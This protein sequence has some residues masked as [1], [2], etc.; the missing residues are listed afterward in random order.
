MK[1]KL[2]IVFLF[3][4]A[5]CSGCQRQELEEM[6][7]TTAV[8]P[9]K[10]D[11]SRSGIHPEGAQSSGQDYVHKVSLRFFPQDGTAPF[12]HYLEGQTK[13]GG[14]SIHGGTIRLP[15]GEYAVVAMNE[16][17]LEEDVYWADYFTFS[18]IN[19]FRDISAHTLAKSYDFT[20]VPYDFYKPAP[21]ET[22]RGEAHKLA[23]WRMEHLLVTDEMIARTRAQDTRAN[24][25]TVIDDTLRVDMLH[26][27]QNI[28]IRVPVENGGSIKHMKGVVNGLMTSRNLS[29]REAGTGYS[30]VLFDF[31]GSFT[32]N[33]GGEIFKEHILRTFGRFEGAADMR[34]KLHM[35]VILI[36][37]TRYKGQDMV[38]D[39]T[40]DLK[41]GGFERDILIT[42]PKLRLP[43]MEGAPTVEDWDDD[44]VIPIG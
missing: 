2:N 14:N 39:I 6:S 21:G 36:D 34:Y 9:V 43:Q 26:V 29:S 35:D 15:K 1:G 7:P 28:K 32:R 37:G 16:T 12:E 13:S 31:D 18:D 4:L 17:V 23:S 44:N 3:V 24:P 30:S 11:W 8:I 25:A 27:T 33:T 22:F 10:V 41:Q 38:F 20:K 42:L 19:S 5:V 40:D